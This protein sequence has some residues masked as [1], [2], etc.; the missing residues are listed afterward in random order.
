[1]GW[2]KRNHRHMPIHS[3][4]FRTPALGSVSPSALTAP[5]T[6]STLMPTSSSKLKLNIPWPSSPPRTSSS[7]SLIPEPTLASIKP[8]FR[9]FR[10]LSISVSSLL[11]TEPGG[12]AVKRSCLFA[13]TRTETGSPT[14]EKDLLPLFSAFFWRRRRM[15]CRYPAASLRFSP[16]SDKA[17]ASTTNMTPRVLS[18]SF[19]EFSDVSRYDRPWDPRSFPWPGVSF[20]SYLTGFLEASDREGS[21]TER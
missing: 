10:I 4:H 5:P 9:D 14:F 1:M 8:L 12:K 16:P 15:S 11:R 7:S 19:F 3:S 18:F 6:T 20:S 17:A 13:A 2:S 21:L